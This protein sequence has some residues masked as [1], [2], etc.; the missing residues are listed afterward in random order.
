MILITVAGH[1]GSD[2]EVRFTPSN[3]KVTSFCVA[4][5]IKRGAKEKT[6]WWK[7]YC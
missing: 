2:P 5:N 3:V 7:I 1:L 4:T 6:V